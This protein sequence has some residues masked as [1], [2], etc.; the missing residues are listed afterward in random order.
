M[1]QGLFFNR[2]SLSNVSFLWDESADQFV[3]AVTSGED[4]TTSG[5]VTLDS[6]ANIQAGVV[7]T[8]GN[9][10]LGED[11]TIIFEG[12]TADAFETTLSDPDRCCLN[13]RELA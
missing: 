5:N 13:G 3:F 10:V 9:V 1:D 6:Y 4:G 7:T 12:A 8:T 11:A 2:G